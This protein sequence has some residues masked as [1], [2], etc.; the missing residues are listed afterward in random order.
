M[1]LQIWYRA[2]YYGSHRMQSRIERYLVEWDWNVERF[3][4]LAEIRGTMNSAKASAQMSYENLPNHH[5]HRPGV[6]Q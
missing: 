1:T 3:K 5:P 2:Y 4:E 6:H